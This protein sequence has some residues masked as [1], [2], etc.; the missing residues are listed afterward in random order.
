MAP[1]INFF[2]NRTI[3]GNEDEDT[4]IVG[5]GSIGVPVEEVTETNKLE[6]EL[7]GDYVNVNTEAQLMSA[8]EEEL[9]EMGSV[10]SELLEKAD[11]G[12]VTAVDIQEGNEAWRNSIARLTQLSNDADL[13]DFGFRKLGNEAFSNPNAYAR[14][15][16]LE[17]IGDWIKKI[18]AKVKEAFRKAIQAV[19]RMAAK[20]VLLFQ[21]YFN[22]AKKLKEAVS[23]LSVSEGGVLDASTQREVVNKLAAMQF[24]SENG[25]VFDD[26][27][28]KTLGSTD[29]LLKKIG[30]NDTNTVIES[31]VSLANDLSET[32]PATLK[33]DGLM[34]WYKKV[35]AL[36][37][38]NSKANTALVS[39]S[40][41]ISDFE[42]D[43]KK[44]KYMVTSLKGNTLKTLAIVPNS[45]IA[46]KEYKE[47][48]FTPYY[49][50]F[51]L[52][53]EYGK[54][55]TVKCMTKQ[56]INTTLDSIIKSVNSDSDTLK[57]YD[58]QVTKLENALNKL[59][60]I[61]GMDLNGEEVSEAMDVIRY[62]SSVIRQVAV[63]YTVDFLWE[64]IALRKAMMY[65][66]NECYKALKEKSDEKKASKK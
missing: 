43:D 25:L 1:R 24:L 66:A 38:K 37:I 18:L 40:G 39:K 46:E 33:K 64:R 49:K 58:K 62:V 23:K 61:D 3:Y 5:D 12:E 56:G 11:D 6:S 63:F 27:F 50:T 10:Q 26:S 35:D 31:L 41:S 22:G 15:I 65:Y 4:A 20:I 54:K 14:V 55:I 45:E 59:T 17:G 21:K 9:A 51:K 16:A 53:M 28:G 52:K 42:E 60:K 44:V 30:K 8:A 48:A 57:Q 34:H 13:A 47:S 29:D 2:G 7:A 19:S 32:N 36:L